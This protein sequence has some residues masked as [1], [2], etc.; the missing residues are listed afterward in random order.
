MKSEA[1]AL[2][3]VEFDSFSNHAPWLQQDDAGCYTAT[4]AAGKTSRLLL[5]KILPD[6]TTLQHPANRHLQQTILCVVANCKSSSHVSI[7]SSSAIATIANNLLL[8]VQWMLLHKIYY[9]RH[10]DASSI[11]AFTTDMALGLDVCIKATL[12]MSEFLRSG[13]LVPGSPEVK[14]LT[15]NQLFLLA[16]I[17]PQYKSKLPTCL[18][19]ANDYLSHGEVPSR[20]QECRPKPIKAAGIYNRAACIELLWS[21][22]ESLPDSL[23]VPPYPR[24]IWPAVS[25]VSRGTEPQ[26]TPTI[27]IDIVTR[28]YTQAIS[29]VLVTGPALLNVRD[30]LESIAACVISADETTRRRAAVLARVN[31]SDIC[32]GWPEPLVG[33]AKNGFG[34]ITIRTAIDCYIPTAAWIVIAGFTA[35][36][37]CELDTLRPCSVSGTAES[38]RWIETYIGKT[39]RHHDKTPCPEIVVRAIELL[40]RWGKH[41]PESTEYLFCSSA[42][43]GRRRNKFRVE[44][45]LDSFAKFVG[46]ADYVVDGTLFWWRYSRHQFRRAFAILYVWVYDSPNLVALSYHF[47]HANVQQTMRYVRDAELNRLIGDES[48]RLTSQRLASI[49][50]GAVE[51]GGILGKR[52]AK[53]VHRFRTTTEIVDD[54]GVEKKLL[55]WARNR[56][57]VLMAT[58]WGYCGIRP[59]ASELQRAECKRNAD[60]LSS[61]G[62][63]DMPNPVASNETTCANCIFHL[64]DSEHIPHWK[65]E[66]LR[67]STAMEA[68][69]G[70]SFL[71]SAYAKRLSLLQQFVSS[72]FPE[73]SQ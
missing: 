14:A 25:R 56:G 72:Q 39:L 20:A 70:D 44:L 8:L 64:T 58:R 53:V 61:I 24:G 34:G 62:A 33:K 45:H 54:K 60:V 28:L 41:E 11:E 12:R 9:F 49:A 40:V 23:E 51:A 16:R 57:L 10:L 26:H 21:L 37:G 47:R 32:K 69:S 73:R 66:I 71:K 38:G 31:T 63:S 6:G 15:V 22:R 30:E 36:R 35:R 65:S 18:S 4:D 13:E 48:Q 42:V 67:I 68:M 27:P 3:D 5:D 2:R 7:D 1:S 50:R 17:P 29:W 46:A 59:V 52:I 43:G 19:L 55:D